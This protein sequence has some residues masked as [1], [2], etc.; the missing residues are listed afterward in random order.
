M[1][2]NMIERDGLSFFHTYKRIPI[3]I[4]RGEGVYL[5]SKDGKRYLD[6]F[7][8]LAVNAL[9]YGHPK[10]LNAID[11]QMK[12]YIHLS[13]YYIAE[14]QIRLAELLISISG[15]QRVFF[16]NSGT[17][18]IEGA[19]KI[20]RK[21]GSRN[22]KSGIISFSN[23]F[24]G[25]TMGALSLM[26]RQKYRDGF[27]PFL[28]HCT[29]VGFNDTAALEKVINDRTAAVVLE[30]IQG[31]GGVVPAT[32]QFIVQLRALQQKFNFLIIA[33]EIQSGLGRTGKLFGFQHYAI[34]PDIVVVAKPLG[35][36]LPL[37]AILGNNNVAGILEPGSHGTT[38]GGNPVACAAGIA[39]M[40][41]I[42]DGALI[43]NA[44][45][46]GILLQNGLRQL[47]KEFP[48]FITDVRGIGLMVGMELAGEGDTLVTK[49]RDH[50][51][52]LN[53]TNRN[54]I[55]FLPPL[56]IHE[57][58]IMATVNALKNIIR[59]IVK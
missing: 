24:H 2:V 16:T 1:M 35:G 28:D 52:L 22:N 15:Y 56:I 20:A 48:E 23:S 57:E 53:C 13:N 38:F 40:N 30:F 55:R 58:E 18:C 19:I 7:T 31:E 45:R 42:M 27:G 29:V 46:M 34:E 32:D 8:G 14:S 43:G 37:G 49:M 4:D 17:E 59:G 21:W 36:G 33:D 41:E 51:I 26:D 44:A 3:E 25:R 5:Y 11:E 12:K 47:M 9:G 6:M 54:V 39:V 50:G 10:I